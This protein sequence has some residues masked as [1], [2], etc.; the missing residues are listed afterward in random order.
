[1]KLICNHQISPSNQKLGWNGSN[2]L[3]FWQWLSNISSKAIKSRNHLLINPVG[4]PPNPSTS[5]RLESAPRPSVPMSATLRKFSPPPSPQRSWRS[6]V[7]GTPPNSPCIPAA[8][9]TGNGCCRRV[10]RTGCA[11]SSLPEFHCPEV[12]PRCL[13]MFGWQALWKHPAISYHQLNYIVYRN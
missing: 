2:P 11:N 7:C 10:S 9:V 8:S 6:G 13:D 3:G 5:P 1:M 12:N 4:P